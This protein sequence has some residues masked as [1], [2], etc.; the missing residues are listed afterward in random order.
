MGF[1]LRH[2][3][4]SFED[5]SEGVNSKYLGPWF[6][7]RWLDVMIKVHTL[8]EF[9]SCKTNLHI[10]SIDWLSDSFT[11]LEFLIC[12]F[13]HEILHK[14]SFNNYVDQFWPLIFVMIT[15][16]TAKL[17]KIVEKKNWCKNLEKTYGEPIMPWLFWCNQESLQL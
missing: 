10:I 4:W 6:L 8:I 12:K 7:S 14:G 16:S 9:L 13:F 11:N 1:V 17:R 2:W 15:F 3:F 5:N